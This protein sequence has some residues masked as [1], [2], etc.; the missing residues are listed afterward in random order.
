MKLAIQPPRAAS[1]AFTLVEILIVVVILGILA[2]IVVPQFSNAAESSKETALQQDVHRFREQLELY[3][4]QHNGNLPTLA[5]FIDQITLASN[6]A[7]D[8]APPG[9]A[10]YPHGP[11]LPGIPRNPFTDTVP[12][13]DGAVGTSAWYYN[14]NTGE[15]APNDSADHRTY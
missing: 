11:Y 5:N 3:K 9:T 12:I 10:G 4:H 1:R 13:G 7:G 6:T 8:T 15:I 2:A 14:E